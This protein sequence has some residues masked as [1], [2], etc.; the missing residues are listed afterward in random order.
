MTPTLL[1]GSATAAKRSPEAIRR[2]SVLGATGSIGTSTLDL[3]GREP[4]RY[5]IVA[6]TA[7]SKVDELAALALKHRPE[8]AVIGAAEHYE[9]LKSRLA[10]SGIAVAA[11]ASGLNE[12]ALRPADWIMSAIVGAAG[13]KPTLAALEQGGVVALANK[14]CLVVGGDLF[15]RR[16]EE[17][18]ATLLP[19]DSEHSAAFQSLAGA[20]QESIEQIVLTAEGG[21]FRTWSLEAR[22]RA[23]P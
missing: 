9:E 21:P 2:V 1:R 23:P 13:L 6:L 15:M 8:L 14:E 18:G 4:E 11:G 7:N 3:V 22:E 17:T 10:G 16:V 19:V 20:E 12:A 5:R